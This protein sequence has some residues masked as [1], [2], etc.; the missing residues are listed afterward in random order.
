MFVAVRAAAAA[1]LHGSQAL[2][3]NP[4]VQENSLP[5]SQGW[6][7]INAPPEEV[8]AYT[9]EADVLPGEAV[10]FHVSTA[11]RYRIKVYRLG[12]Y[13]GDGGRL[14]G[15]I[16]ADCTHDQQGVG[17]P[18]PSPEAGTY[19]VV[20]RW[21][22]TDTFQT[23]PAAVSGYYLAR[24]VLDTGVARGRAGTV[25]FV[26][27]PPET[28]RSTVLVQVPVNTWEA[29]NAWGGHSLYDFNSVN[30]QRANRVSF[31]RPYGY[32]AQGPL[33]LEL[34]LVRFLEREGVDVSYQTDLDTHFS[35][36]SLLSHRLVMVAGHDEYWTKE[37]RDAFDTARS[38]GTNLAFMGSNDGYWQVRYEDG[39]RTIVG[40]KDAAADPIADPAQKT[41]RFRDL[42]RPECEL[43]GVMFYF[44][45]TLRETRIDY[46]VTNAAL[47]DP[48]FADTGFQPGDRVAAVVNDE[49]D[50]IAAQPP[51]SCR[52]PDLTVLF[53]YD[54][55]TDRNQNADAVRYTAPSGARV[56][57]AGAQ[58][59]SWG[60][61][62]VGTK[63]PTDPRLQKFVL[64]ML[65]DLT[66]PAPPRSY[67]IR[68]V[69]HGVRIQ[70]VK[71]VDPR[72]REIEIFRQD[73]KGL[74]LIAQSKTGVCTDRPKQRSGAV[75]Y[76]AESVD[77]WGKSKPLFAT[78]LR[79]QAGSHVRG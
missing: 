40:Y 41:I 9:S 51:S 30:K 5:G 1:L 63:Q 16:P 76:V 4:V 43:E 33:Q 31:D 57:S 39:G 65:D 28:Q 34:Q 75:R 46:T 58:R 78:P 70:F 74:V 53:H 73:D 8:E 72:I 13:N 52:K 15:C 32:G 18:V 10:H 42:G 6:S 36:S 47:H 60:L 68:V 50:A 38:L 64:N 2:E 44:L 77:E 61:D 7:R 12:W 22:V 14:I 25:P 29:Y 79:L 24:I 3:S 55:T 66:R 11:E 48:W 62:N 21:P 27:R 19:R 35:P 54:G 20:A 37:M 26:V 67:N 56:F 49:W 71:G 23:P 59:F 45:R 69:K 17:Y